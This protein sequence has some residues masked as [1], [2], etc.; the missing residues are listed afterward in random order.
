MCIHI[1]TVYCLLCYQQMSTVKPMLHPG[2]ILFSSQVCLKVRHHWFVPEGGA[3]QSWAAISLLHPKKGPPRTSSLC[4]WW[5]GCAWVSTFPSSSNLECMLL[6]FIQTTRVRVIQMCSITHSILTTE[7]MCYFTGGPFP[8]SRPWFDWIF[9]SIWLHTR[10]GFRNISQLTLE[11]IAV[12][13]WP[14]IGRFL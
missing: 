11:L 7:C 10:L 2:V 6:V 9:F 8:W 1:F 14:P 4:M 5:S 12:C 3:R 13:F